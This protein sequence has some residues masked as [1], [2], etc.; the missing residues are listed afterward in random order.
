MYTKIS[1]VIKKLNPLNNIKIIT[2]VNYL[3]LA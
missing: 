1:A 2:Y 3:M